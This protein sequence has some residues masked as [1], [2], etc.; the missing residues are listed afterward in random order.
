MNILKAGAA[1]TAALFLTGCAPGPT[2]SGSPSPSSTPSATPTST[3]K[4]VTGEPE[5]DEFIAV[6]NASCK[7]GQKVGLAVAIP[8]E[9]Q[10]TYAFPQSDFFVYG[11]SWNMMTKTTDGYQIGGWFDGDVLCNEAAYANRV[12][13]KG[14]APNANG[15]VFNYKYVEV[16]PGTVDWSVNREMQSFDPVRFTFVNGLVTSVEFTTTKYVF[17]TTYG[18]FSKSV[19]DAYQAALVSSG[20][21]YMYL[22]PPLWGMTLAQAKAYCKKKGLTVVVGVKDGEDFFPSGPPGGIS[23]PKRMIVYI[24]NGI[25]SDVVTM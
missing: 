3:V 5:V 4:V 12:V 7:Q 25:I 9:K 17:K 23:D 6:L 21:Q 18:P 8:K 15:V 22:S 20:Q 2:P 1:I 14:S 24:Y 16:K 19:K 11:Q 10:T 13:P